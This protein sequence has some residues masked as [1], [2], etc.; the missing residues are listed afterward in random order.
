METCCLTKVLTRSGREVAESKS[1]AFAQLEVCLSC[2]KILREHRRAKDLAA[3]FRAACSVAAA[4]KSV[5]HLWMIK[6]II[7]CLCMFRVRF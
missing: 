5:A 6:R 4:E 2:A 1:S 7:L 3:I